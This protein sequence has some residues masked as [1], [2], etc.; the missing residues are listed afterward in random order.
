MTSSETESKHD[1]R[2]YTPRAQAS[3]ARSSGSYGTPRSYRSS[4]I[5]SSSDDGEYATPRNYDSSSS[6]PTF[7]RSYQHIGDA[8]TMYPNNRRNLLPPYNHHHHHHHQSQQQQHIQQQDS[9]TSQV[10]YSNNYQINHLLFDED[11]GD[12]ESRGEIS[13]MYKR[14]NT[15]FHHAMMEPSKKDI[16][17]IFSYTRHGR[18]QEVDKLLS[19]GVPPDVIDENG[20][21][22]L[23]IACQNGNKR[24]A[25]LALRRGANINASN[26]RGNTALHFCYKYD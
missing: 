24:L 13:Q 11:E 6:N 25:K 23:A 1:E 21:S 2:F 4:S 26:V 12:E 22:I 19:K 18:I 5:A 10:S 16:E 20:N 8:T 9:T 3:T 14:S 7:G 15:H 17:S